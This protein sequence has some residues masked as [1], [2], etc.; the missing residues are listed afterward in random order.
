M[1]MTSMGRG[2]EPRRAALA[3]G[4]ITTKLPKDKEQSMM[5]EGVPLGLAEKEGA[6]QEIQ[7]LNAEIEQR[8]A[9]IEALRA[10]RSEVVTELVYQH[11][12]RPGGKYLYMEGE[13][14]P[15]S[16]SESLK[17]GCSG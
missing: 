5:E 8:M 9:E 10:R 4:L 6:K 17:D 11:R 3:T 13:G 16:R 1:G 12:P 14:S 15:A 7:R 2:R